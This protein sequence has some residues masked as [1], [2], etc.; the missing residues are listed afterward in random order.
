MT[1]PDRRIDVRANTTGRGNPSGYPTDQ[2]A[3]G[4][5]MSGTG[6]GGTHDVGHGQAPYSK[7]PYGQPIDPYAQQAVYAQQAQHAHYAAQQAANPYGQPAY[8]TAAQYVPPATSIP[9]EPPKKKRCAA[10]WIGLI[11]ALLCVALA[12]IVALNIFGGTT[13]RQGSLGQ[14]DG[15]SDEEIQAELDRVVDEGMFNISI[16]ASILFENGNAPGEL[17]I[18]NVP[19]NRYLMKVDIVRDDTGEI[20]YTTDLIEPNHHIQSDTLDV[21]LPAGLYDCT[22]VFEAYDPETEEAIGQA[23]ANIVIQIM[24]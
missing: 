18:E 24:N 21:S 10:F 2:A 15:K 8:A 9:H 4:Y 17:R 1:Q 16:A 19:G 23:A 3:M 5:G 12:V 20:I 22:A 14:L 6:H 11:I 7:Q 13:K